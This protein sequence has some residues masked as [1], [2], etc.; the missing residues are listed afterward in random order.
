MSRLS[1]P[2]QM[3]IFGRKSCILQIDDSIACFFVKLGISIKRMSRRMLY[4]VWEGMLKPIAPAPR[5]GG[6]GA[7]TEGSEFFL[8][9]GMGKDV[10][11]NPTNIRSGD[12]QFYLKSI[13]MN[14]AL[15]KLIV[16]F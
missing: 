4:N 12:S 6:G 5:L 13:L 8:A 14:C 16:L 7:S 11:S 15:N 9:D 3:I 10:L 1:T 2:L